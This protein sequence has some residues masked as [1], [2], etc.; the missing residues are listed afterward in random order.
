M[1]F[2]S[3]DLSIYGNKKIFAPLITH[4]NKLQCD[5]IK[6]NHEKY[7][8]LKL[9]PILFIG[10]NLGLN[11]IFGFSSSFNATYYCR[12]CKSPKEE[13]QKLCREDPVAM[14]NKSNYELDCGKNN[15]KV[16]GIKENSI[17]NNL[18]QFHV[19]CNPSVDLMH[20]FLEGVC[21]VVLCS[22]LFNFV[23]VRQLFTLKQFN[24]RLKNHNFGPLEKNTNIP[25]ITPEMLKKNK[26]RISASEMFVLFTHFAFIIGDYV[27]KDIPEWGLYL[28]TRDILGIILEKKVHK[29]TPQL[30]RSLICGHHELF[31]KLF[32]KKFT[33][34]MHFA[35][36]YPNIMEQI[37][38]LCQVSSMRFESYHK[39][40]KIIVKNISCRKNLLKSCLF[41]LKMRYANFFLNFKSF[42]DSKIITAK[43]SQTSRDEIVA[44]YRC[45]F[46]LPENLF[47]TNMVEKNSIVYKVGLVIQS[48]VDA[49]DT[50]TF[51]IITNI[52]VHKSN[53]FLG[54]QSLKVLGFSTHF[55]SFRVEK[56]DFKF[57]KTTNS[58]Y[59]RS[60]YVF[61]GINHDNYVLWD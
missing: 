35:I 31:K 13:M 49:D 44:N 19:V 3:C 54:C 37:G 36:H 1:L 52:F 51:A 41:K 17:F 14:R 11:S 10:D 56:E 25:L 5:G 32:T 55:H 50:P 57:I 30:L 27:D 28:L 9:L 47:V 15:F 60:S 42:Y 20:D 7:G 24:H 40:F 33:P 8:I 34:K 18:K 38:P 26:V 12:F 48:G 2:F 58:K 6:L 61:L 43:L 53:I 4:L 45:E 21:H 22:I 39:I 29:D 23:Y 16:T 59:I 46:P